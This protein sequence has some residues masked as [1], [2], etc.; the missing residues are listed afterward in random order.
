MEYL[1]AITVLLAV[2][3][4]VCLLLPRKIRGVTFGAGLI[5]LALLIGWQ[6]VC[7]PY[8]WARIVQDIGGL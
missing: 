4:A 6:L 7:Y 5:N 1:L 8:R 2:F 3:A